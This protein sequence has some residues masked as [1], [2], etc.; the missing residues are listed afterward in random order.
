M[1]P[2]DLAASQPI[3]GTPSKKKWIPSLG[4]VTLLSN[5]V[6]SSSDL[7]VINDTGSERN[8]S[9]GKTCLA[10]SFIDTEIVNVTF[11]SLSNAE[12]CFA[13]DKPDIE[14]C[15]WR[16]V[17][18]GT[19][20]PPSS[21]FGIDVLHEPPNNVPFDYSVSSTELTGKWSMRLLRDWEV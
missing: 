7:D 1:S 20:V 19:G 5:V 11:S 15:G 12:S 4:S 14:E 17:T 2:F 6:I 10:D 21:S 9:L 3:L 13:V 8:I 16:A 18:S